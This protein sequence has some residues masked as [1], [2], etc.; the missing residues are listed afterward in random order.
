M[1]R[2]R[3]RSW[4]GT[5]AEWYNYPTLLSMDFIPG[6]KETITDAKHNLNGLGRYDVGGP[7][8]LSRDKAKYNVV[9]FVS[10]T[11]K[12][13]HTFPDTGSLTWAQTADSAV[14]TKGLGTTGIARTTPTSPLFSA[15]QFLGEIRNDGV[16]TVLGVQA[17]REKT[18]FYRGLGKEYL[19]AEFGWSPFIDDVRKF[20]SVVKHFDQDYGHFAQ[21]SGQNNHVDYTFPPTKTY[22]TEFME[23]I[24]LLNCNRTVIGS[25]KG[26]TYGVSTKRTWFSGCWTYHVPSLSGPTAD[27]MSA[28][29]TYANHL[30]GVRL[31]PEV[32]WNLSPWTWALDWFGNTGDIIHNVSTIGHDGLVLKYGYVMHH[33]RLELSRYVVGPTTLGAQLP[34]GQSIEYVLETK[35]R[36]QANPYFGFG[37]VGSL[38]TTQLAILAALGLSRG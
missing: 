23:N 2:T 28:Y 34:S 22:K 10:G 4:N 6:G 26:N 11:R 29:A 30:L 9:K 37:A 24:P 8:A 18:R 7:M 36:F 15:S 19:N 25:G 33:C 20:A 17:W 14:T 21:Q 27:R 13:S 38:S 5:L 32:L 1:L 16:P 35:T 3:T 12:G 31:T